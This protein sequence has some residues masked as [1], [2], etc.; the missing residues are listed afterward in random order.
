[1]FGSWDLEL[2][3]YRVLGGRSDVRTTGRGFFDFSGLQTTHADLN[4]AH[5]SVQK[6]D[7]HLLEVRVEAAARNA[8]DLF[9]DPAGLFRETATNDRIAGQRFLFA[10]SARFHSP[11]TFQF[12]LVEIG[13]I[14]TTV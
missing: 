8:G 3:S 4:T 6:D 10:D 1:M 13:A 9:A 12:Q 2:G 5:R 14:P 7:F 11:N